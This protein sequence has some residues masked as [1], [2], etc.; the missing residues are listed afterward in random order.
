VLPSE[1]VTVPEGAV[2]PLTG[3][4]RAA[5]TVLPV[6]SRFAGVAFRVTEVDIGDAVTEIE[7]EAVELPKFPVAV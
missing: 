2:D 5:K 4:T 3:L 7:T 6:V 1:N